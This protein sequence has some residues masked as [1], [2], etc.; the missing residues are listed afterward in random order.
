MSITGITAE[1]ASARL[2]QYLD[3][4]EKVLAGQA[5]KFADGRE[6]TRADLKEI[7]EGLDYWSAK[8]DQL[9]PVQRVLPRPRAVG[10]VRRGVMGVR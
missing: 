10:R 4:E 3:A 1:V 2:Q 6:L 5:F 7:R 9:N 8:V